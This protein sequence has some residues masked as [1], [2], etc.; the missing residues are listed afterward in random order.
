MILTYKL[1]EGWQ[2]PYMLLL[3][4]PYGIP[5]AWFIV[6][7]KSLLFE[8]WR[9]VTSTELKLLY[10]SFPYSCLQLIYFREGNSKLYGFVIVR[11]SNSKLYSLTICNNKLYLSINPHAIMCWITSSGPRALLLLIILLTNFCSSNPH[12]MLSWW[13]PLYAKEFVL[14]LLVSSCQLQVGCSGVVNCNFT[15]LFHSFLNHFKSY[16]HYCHCRYTLNRFNRYPTLQ[17][18]TDLRL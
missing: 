14:M 9:E 2:V 18:K 16:F 5:F 8:L 13:P 3:Y 4:C 10:F 17:I 11:A 1:T 15:T 6:T 7:S 12:V